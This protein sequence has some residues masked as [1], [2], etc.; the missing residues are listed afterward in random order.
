[1]KRLTLI[2]SALCVFTLLFA[3]SNTPRIDK[4]LRIYSDIMRQLDM[5]YTDTLPYEQMLEAGVAAMLK[6]VDP[7]T[8]YYPKQKEQDIRLMTT[9]KYGGIG[10]IIQQQG[11]SVC[12]SNPY[13]GMPAQKAGLRAGDIIVRIDSTDVKGLKTD[14]VSKLLR[15]NPG[16]KIHLEVIRE[17]ER[18]SFDFEREDIT[19][20]PVSYTALLPDSSGY[21]CFSEF[22]EKSSKVFAHAVD[23]LGGLGM[24][25]LVIDLRGNGGGL[26]DEAVKIMSL[27]VERGTPIVTVKGRRTKDHTY[28]T[29][30]NPKYKDLPLI[31]LVDR[32]TASAAEIVSGAMQDLDR[33]IVAGTRTYGKGLVQN[34]RPIAYDGQLKLTTAKYYIPSGRCIQ[35]IDYSKRRQDGSVERVPDSLTHTFKTRLGRTVRD[36]GGIV[37]DLLVEEDTT[38]KVNITYDLYRKQMYFRYAN[39]YRNR[40]ATVPPLSQI[41]LDYLRNA[42]FECV[43][44]YSANNDYHYNECC[45]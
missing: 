23:S 37:P 17:T 15:G 18:L 8:I 10:A 4:H 7:Y 11:D 13:K 9:G 41:S 27:F 34:I 14:G 28:R 36:G 6:R 3:D 44:T 21:I 29:A 31:V 22:T 12:V 39:H 30:S 26:I 35:A 32:Q 5:Y 45:Q 1:M 40:H 38:K 24:K 19:L 42:M 2:F 33:A 43:D 25:R 16:S 20:S